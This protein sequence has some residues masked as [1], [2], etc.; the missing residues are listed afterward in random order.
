MKRYVIEAPCRQG[1]NEH[2]PGE[3]RKSK[4]LPPGTSWWAARRALK[5]HARK[6]HMSGPYRLTKEKL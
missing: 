1:C 2:Q 5:K 6:F 3:W 4:R